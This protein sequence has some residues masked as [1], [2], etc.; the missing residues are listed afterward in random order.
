MVRPFQCGLLRVECRLGGFWKEQKEEWAGMQWD[1]RLGWHSSNAKTLRPAAS[2]I[3][4]CIEPNCSAFTA[5]AAH[6][7][8]D[9]SR[10]RSQQVTIHQTSTLATGLDNDIANEQ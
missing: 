5:L 4:V 9:R 6:F 1:G 10:L 3:C 7:R 8:Q 2:C